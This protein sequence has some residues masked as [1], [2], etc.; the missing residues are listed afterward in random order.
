MFNGLDVTGVTN[1]LINKSYNLGAFSQEKATVKS[2]EWL[3][4]EYSLDDLI[5]C[6]DQVFGGDYFVLGLPF[7]REKNVSGN[8]MYISPIQIVK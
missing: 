7:V 8:H 4:I 3:T 6:Y 5:E 2:N 1:D